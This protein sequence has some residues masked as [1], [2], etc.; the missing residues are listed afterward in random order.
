MPFRLRSLA[1]L[2][3]YGGQVSSYFKINFLLGFFNL[4]I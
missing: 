1:T 2:Y 4:K 3:R